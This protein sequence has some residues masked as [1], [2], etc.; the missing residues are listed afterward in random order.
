M[1]SCTEN[2]NPN[3]PIHLFTTRGVGTSKTFTLM[4]L[5]QALIH[6]YNRHSNLD[7]LK[8]KLCSWH[9]F[10]KQHVT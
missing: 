10:K 5:V 1:M 2:K 7:P 8:R 4:F 6:F 3:E 9:I